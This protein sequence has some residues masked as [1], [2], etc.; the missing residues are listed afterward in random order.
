MLTSTVPYI[1]PL[2]LCEVSKKYLQEVVSAV[3]TT[4]TRTDQCNY[5]IE[6]RFFAPPIGMSVA[7]G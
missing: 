5:D 7:L 2:T 3:A 1:L 6:N 4:Y